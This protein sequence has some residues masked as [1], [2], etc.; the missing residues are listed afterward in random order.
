EFQI[1]RD[2]V[3][4]ESKATAI[5]DMQTKYET[6]KKEQAIQLLNKD[7]E[8]QQLQIK[9]QQD[10]IQKSTLIAEQE[11]Q[12]NTLQALTISNQESRIKQ[13]DL[14]ATNKGNEVKLLNQQR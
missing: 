2:S 3:F 12:K 9:R 8:I 7:K 14:E 5:A 6:E 11:R 13:K 10:E 1:Y 4:N